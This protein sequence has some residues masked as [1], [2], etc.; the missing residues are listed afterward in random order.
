MKSSVVI[1][2][3]GC[4]T[5]LGHTPGEIHEAMLQGK[6]AYSAISLFDASACRCTIGGEIPDFSIRDLGISGSNMMLRYNKLQ[7]KAAYQMLNDYGLIAS[8]ENN[9][10]NCAVYVANHPVNLDPEMLQIIRSICSSGGA[11]AMDFSKL[12]DNLHRIPPLSGVKQLTTVPSHFIAKTTGAHGPGNL[13]CNSDCGGVTALLSAARAIETGRI[14]QAMVSASFSPFSAHEFRWWL[15]TGFVR[16][17][18]AR[19]NPEELVTPFSPNSS[20]TLMSEGAGAIF[21][22]REEVALS[23]GRPILA[24][25]QGGASLTVPGETYFGLSGTGFTN[26]LNLAL[27]RARF[28]PDDID[29]MMC[30]APSVAA[31]DDAELEGI[32]AVWNGSSVS[33]AALK[34]YLGYLGPVSGLLDVILAVQS[35]ISQT[36]VPLNHTSARS[37]SRLEWVR[38]ENAAMDIERTVVNSAGPGG[39]YSAI[40]L[41]KGGNYPR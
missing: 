33:A 25:I 22:E 41:E 32:S 4:V 36:A 27:E 3:M 12:G 11:G 24:R 10:M 13:Y 26:T 34:G 40:I 14:D 1:T 16:S 2:G 9:A 23:N 28:A 8:L 15:E 20:G 37:D 30:N 29:L 18:A 6:T 35:M 39:A 38:A 7:M 21:L 19:E 31:W 5:P 17:T